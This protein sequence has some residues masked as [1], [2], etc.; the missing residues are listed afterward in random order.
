LKDIAIFFPLARNRPEPTS[1]RISTSQPSLALRVLT[2]AYLLDAIPAGLFID[3]PRPDMEVDK[4]VLP[5]G[6]PQDPHQ[7]QLR[8]EQLTTVILALIW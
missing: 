4:G 8:D 6:P 5:P 2:T 3:V 1:E 7:P